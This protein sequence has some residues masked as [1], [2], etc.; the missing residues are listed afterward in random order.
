[1]IDAQIKETVA[2]IQKQTAL[3]PRLAIVLG[4][5]LSA[6]AKNVKVA[7]EFRFGDLPHFASS[8]VEGHPGRLTLG[9]IEGVPVA[10]MQG[11]LHAYEGLSTEQVMYPVR[12]LAALGVSA[13]LLTNAAGGLRADVK[14]GAFMVIRDH[15]N[16]TGINPLRGPNW[17]HGPRFV[18]MTDAYDPALTEAMLH[19]MKAED[20][21]HYDGVYVGVM[22]PS[23][24]TAAEVK[25]FGAMGAGAVGMSTVFETIAARHAGIKVAGL[26]CITNQ[27]TG[28]SSEK[29]SHEEVKTVA[30][31]VEVHFARAVKRFVRE[32]AAII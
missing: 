8:G 23:Y 24:E 7:A 11:R 12:V 28:L 19:A 1:M 13:V 3:K 17:A 16:M 31:Q 10:L 2:F 15:I 25:Y 29:L 22:G 14:P 18:D 5:G 9:E 21:R 6:F 27:G 26:S 32:V 20:V 30:E 4:S